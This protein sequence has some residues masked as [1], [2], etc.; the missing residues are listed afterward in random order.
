MAEKD[1]QMAMNSQ[2]DQSN[3]TYDIAGKLFE[4]AQRAPQGSATRRGLQN[5]FTKKY[6]A[7]EAMWHIEREQ[8]KKREGQA[9]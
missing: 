2:D 8:E 7:A 1:R 4:A 9:G 6:M 5:A 3:R